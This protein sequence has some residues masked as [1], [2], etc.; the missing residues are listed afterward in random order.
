[1][2]ATHLIRTQ[3][4]NSRYPQPHS[5]SLLRTSNTSLAF[6]P[7]RS[8]LAAPK[9]H[10]SSIDS[11]TTYNIGSCEVEVADVLVYRQTWHRSSRCSAHGRWDPSS[12]SSI[13]YQ[14]HCRGY[15]CMYVCIRMIQLV[16]VI[17]MGIYITETKHS[18]HHAYMLHLEGDRCSDSGWCRRYH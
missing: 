9:R 8:A 3:S 14:L 12:H 13:G 15:V 11:L 10:P 17:K 16:Q 1:M 2:C 4:S 18:R 6:P 5:R 7:R